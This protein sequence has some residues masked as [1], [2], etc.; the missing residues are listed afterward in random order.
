VSRDDAVNQGLDN[1]TIEVK[2]QLKSLSFKA[3]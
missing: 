2:K 3:Q 1:L